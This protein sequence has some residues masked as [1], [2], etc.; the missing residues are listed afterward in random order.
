MLVGSMSR[1]DALPV[2]PFP[3]AFSVMKATGFDSNCSLSF[4]LGVLDEL[5]IG[6]DSSVVKNLI[7]VTYERSA[8]T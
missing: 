8:V 2:L 6:K 1:M 7:K 4:P 3:P 5:R